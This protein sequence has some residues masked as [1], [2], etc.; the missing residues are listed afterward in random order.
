MFKTKTRPSG[1]PRP[2]VAPLPVPM[3]VPVPV[4][5]K[6]VGPN[7][8]GTSKSQRHKAVG[9]KPKK[10]GLRPKKRSK[11]VSPRPPA[12]SGTA[13]A[14]AAKTGKGFLSV[15]TDSSARVYIGDRPSALPAPL[16]RLP[17]ESGIHRIRVFFEETKSF[18]DTQ[19]VSIKPGQTFTLSFSSPTNE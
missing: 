7:K 16:K 14:K 12:G 10:G 11:P 1:T 2:R 4:A 13:P 19:W 8:K 6:E 3:P 9:K 5:I 17:M 18:S 15:N